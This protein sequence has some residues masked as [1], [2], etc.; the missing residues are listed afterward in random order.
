M[1]KVNFWVMFV[2]SIVANTGIATAQ[3]SNTPQCILRSTAWLPS[4]FK[5]TLSNKGFT[6]IDDND[7]YRTIGDYVLDL[8]TDTNEITP[9]ISEKNDGLVPLTWGAKAYGEATLSKVVEGAGIA[10]PG[11]GRPPREVKL[12]YN[13]AP[14][15]KFRVVSTGSAAA[16]MKSALNKEFKK[17][18]SCADLTRSP[19]R[20]ESANESENESNEGNHF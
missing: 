10:V 7:P 5:E 13:Y 14:V 20:F 3:D 15:K 16:T 18:P 8:N 6:V 12:L 1:K 11:A 19:S 4:E 17:G 2:A 9:G